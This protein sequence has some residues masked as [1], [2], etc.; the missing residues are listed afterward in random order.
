MIKKIDITLLVECARSARDGVTRNHVFLVFSSIAKVI[1]GIILEHILDILSIIGKSTVTQVCWFILW[2]CTY[3]CFCFMCFV[4]SLF[5][6][7][8]RLGDPL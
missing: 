6:I 5:F 3:S 4:V 8:H 2:P 1:P 7:I